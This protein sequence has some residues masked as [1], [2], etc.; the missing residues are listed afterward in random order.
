MKTCG[1]QI[2]CR[3]C[4]AKSKRTGLQC[5]RPAL[6]SSKTQKC[7][8]HGGRSTGPKTAAGKAKIAAAALK[9]GQYTK[10]AIRAR[11]VNT[12]YMLRLEDAMHH[13]GMISGTRTRGPKPKSYKPVS[14]IDEIATLEKEGT[15]TLAGSL[16][17]G[18][19]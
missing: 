16:A 9:S 4:L 7:Q 14:S 18:E 2:Q 5:G 11:S 19:E 3:R 12:A 8:F 17:K 1:G 15:I 6:N 13:L 10:A